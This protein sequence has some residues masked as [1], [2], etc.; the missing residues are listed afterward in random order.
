MPRY[1]VLVSFF[2]TPQVF[3]LAS[4]FCQSFLVSLVLPILS[5]HCI[6]AGDPRTPSTTPAIHAHR[7]R[8]RSTHPGRLRWRAGRVGLGRGPLSLVSQLQAGRFSYYFAPDDS[9]S[10]DSFIHFVD[11]AAPQ[12]S[13]AVSTPLLA[14][15]DYPNAYLVGLV[16]VRV[17][18]KDLAIR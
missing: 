4:S 14:S 1:T 10:A 17:D 5:L 9:V 13:H 11:D 15:S 3:F 7:R 6:Y 16:G 12:T 18:G 8:R 2:C